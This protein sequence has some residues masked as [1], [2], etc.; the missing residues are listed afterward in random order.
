MAGNVP[1]WDNAAIARLKDAGA[2]LLGKSTTPEFGHKARPTPAPRL[3]AQPL[4]PERP[5]RVGRRAAVAVATGMGPVGVS[6]DGAARPA[7]RHPP[8]ASSA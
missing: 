8:A 4:N 2:I 3:D 1:D 6:T 5:R 7:S